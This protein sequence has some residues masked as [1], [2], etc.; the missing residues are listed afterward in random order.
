[1]AK[2]LHHHD[3]TCYKYYLHCV[4]MLQVQTPMFHKY[5]TL[6]QNIKDLFHQ[7]WHVH[8]MW[9]GNS[10][11]NFLFKLESSSFNII[12]HTPFWLT[13]Y[14]LLFIYTKRTRFASYLNKNQKSK[15]K[16][17]TRNPEPETPKP[18]P[19]TPN[20]KPR[21]RNPKPQ[22]LNLGCPYPLGACDY[23]LEN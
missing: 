17:Q 1:M 2:Q 15:F 14:I 21:T 11:A 16:T 3:I 8:T 9:E 7:D 5:V 10:Y 6:I 20:Q 23:S 13:S 4:D 12:V 19:Q 18:K 22:T